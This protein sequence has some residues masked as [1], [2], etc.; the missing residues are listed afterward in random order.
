MDEHRQGKQRDARIRN[1]VY[2]AALTQRLFPHFLKLESMQPARDPV[3]TGPRA[4]LLSR[5][6]AGEVPADGRAVCKSHSS[7]SWTP[8]S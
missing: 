8:A 4:P 2:C 3:L 7:A 1:N 5:D 6:E